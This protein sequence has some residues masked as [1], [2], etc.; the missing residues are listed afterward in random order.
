MRNRP[1]LVAMQRRT[2]LPMHWVIPAN[3][4]AYGS[5]RNKHGSS[6]NDRRGDNRRADRCSYHHCRADHN[7][8]EV[9]D[10]GLHAD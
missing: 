8:T 7:H 3:R 1:D 6:G 2:A 4:C 9:Y 10:K 5:P